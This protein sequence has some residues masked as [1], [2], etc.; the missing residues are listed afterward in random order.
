[1]T[2]TA[3]PVDAAAYAE[4]ERALA[5]LLETDRDAV[6]L[7]GE[8]ILVL[9]ALALGLGGPG[10]RALNLV[11]G[12]YGEQIG[13][14]LERGGATVHQLACEFDR[15]LDRGE[16]ARA[17]AE[18]RFD[19][20]SIVH[21]E[22]AT[23][24]VNPLA[25]I[26]ALAHASGAIVVVDAVA[27]VGAEPLRIDDWN[28]DLVAIGPQKGLSGPNGVCAL[29]AGPAG[30]EAIERNP[31]APRESILSLLDVKREWI[32][33]GRRRLPFYASDF[34]MRALGDALAVREQEGIAA[35][36]ERHRRARDAVR[37]G[38]RALGLQPW[39]AADEQAAAVATLVAP[40]HA[41]SPKRLLDAS[42]AA[43]P[44]AR[45][46]LLA[47]AP[48]PLADTALRIN[49]TGDG[50]AT[51]PVLEALGALSLGLRELELAPDAGAALEAALAAFG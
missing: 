33:A 51:A 27:S 24:A 16:V 20:V 34:E 45:P 50:A 43:L 21:A 10:V 30:W 22:A 32:D 28:L 39:I 40:P 3:R 35:C 9:E 4:L 12:P 48:G 29:I 46:G 26:A 23:G 8:A 14:W 13:R 36:V 19:V 42:A 1:M 2:P 44:G 15:A 47:L 25:E 5:R 49:H 31:R 11:S 17:L 7:Q 37:A 41:I 6:I 18:E 38:I